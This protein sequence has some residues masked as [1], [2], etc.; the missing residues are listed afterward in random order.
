MKQLVIEI[1]NVTVVMTELVVKLNE[2]NQ[3][4]NS[5]WKCNIC[6]QI[7]TEFVVKSKWTK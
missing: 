6:D 4:I 2:S 7:I 5:N 1:E 3:L